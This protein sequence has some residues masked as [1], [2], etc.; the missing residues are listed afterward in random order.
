MKL[1]R[2]LF[3]IVAFVSV[4]GA[5]MAQNSGQHFAKDGLSFDYPSGWVID[6]SKNSTPMQYLTLGRDGYASI[7]VRSP[8]GLIDTPEKETLVKHF[9]QDGFV[10]AWV[11]NFE[12]SG[13]KPERSVVSTEIAGGPAEC[14]RLSASLSGEPG[15]VDVCWRLVEKRMVQLAI[16]GSTKDIT[17]TTPVWDAIRNSVKI[18][19]PPPKA[20]PSLESGQAVV[21]G[22]LL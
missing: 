17:R 1:S 18:V 15:H 14:T 19:P 6:E 13:A 7:I 11:K 10:D 9:I 22:T 4:L 20:T 21:A 12:S 8:R 16:I 2:K 3:L 5:A